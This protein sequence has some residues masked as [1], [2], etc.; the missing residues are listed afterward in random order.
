MWGK[1]TVKEDIPV[2]FAEECVRR[3]TEV[4]DAGV[5][6]IR[7]SAAADP[8]YQMM[9]KALKEGKT[10]KE[11]SNSHPVK[12]MAGIWA[13]V[14]LLDNKPETHGSHYSA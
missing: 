14:S 2:Y 7:N 4:E 13:R 9:I 10:P 3:V 12:D 1:E 11:C 8:G 5:E 6:A